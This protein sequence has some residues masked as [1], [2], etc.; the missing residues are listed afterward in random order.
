MAR[1]EL[2]KSAMKNADLIRQK[3]SETKDAQAAEY[4]GVDASTICRFKAEHLDKFCAYLDFF[5][6]GGIRERFKSFD[7]Q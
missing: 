1:N 6:I 5:R 7:R 2:S 4:V 3:A